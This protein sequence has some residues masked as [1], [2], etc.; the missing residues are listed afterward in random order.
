M[1]RIGYKAS[2]EQFGPRELLD[3][4]EL[5]ERLGYDSVFV[6]DHFQPWRHTGGHAPFSLAWLGALGARTSRIVMGTSVLT[7]TFRY[8]PAIIAQ[9]FA[10]LGSL[11]PGRV[12]LGLGSGEALN[13]TPAT[14]LAWPEPRERTRRLREALALIERLWREERVSFAGE[15]YRTERATIYDKPAEPVPIY[16]AAAGP[17]VRNS[18]ARTPRGSSQRAAS[19]SSCIATRCCPRS[20]QDSPSRAGQ[21]PRSSG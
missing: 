5:A 7:P 6:S 20:P 14:A 12:I 8:H 1:L 15:Y 2:A 4:A 19:R 21:P 10:T 9:A 16:V 13:E 18:P 11:F 3:L 17:V